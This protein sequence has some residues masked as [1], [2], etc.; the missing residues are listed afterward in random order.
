MYRKWPTK[1]SRKYGAKRRPRSYR[2]LEQARHDLG[3]PGE[4]VA[5]IEGRLRSQQKLLGKTVVRR[6]AA[7]G[8]GPGP[9][10]IR[11]SKSM[12]SHW[13]WLENGGVGRNAGCSPA[14]MGSC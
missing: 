13:A 14:L 7:A 10:M 2:C 11:Y 4:L 12:V 1:E 5:E 6:R 8:N 3:L 9:P